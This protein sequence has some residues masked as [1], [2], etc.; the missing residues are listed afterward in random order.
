MSCA[1][2]S[3]R[4]EKAVSALDGVKEC[5]V[6]LLT[7]TMNVEG[8]ATREQIIAAVEKAGYGAA[9]ADGSDSSGSEKTDKKV[10]K[11]EARAFMV[12]LIS[13]AVL[14]CVLMYFSMGHS[15][16]G[17]RVPAFFEDNYIAEAMLQMLLCIAVMVI[18]KKFFVSGFTALAHRAPNMDTLVAIGSG[19][20][21]VYSV[22]TVFSMTAD[23]G[24]HAM[25]LVHSLYFESAAMIL[26]LI[27][28]GKTLEA[29]SKGKTTS[30]LEE[31]I[32]LTP[33]TACVIRDGKEETIPAKDVRVG[34]IYVVR[35]GDS[36][37]ADGVIVK[38]NSAINESVLTGESIPAD[39][40]EGDEVHAATINT[41]GYLECRATRVG[42]DTALSQII[43]LVSDA[44]ATKAP[45]AKTADRVAG[46]FVPAVM[47]IA[48]LTFISWMIT[49]A[50]VGYA[51]ARAI[52]VLVISCPCALGLATPVA[53][54]VASGVGAKNGIL[55]KSAASIEAAGRI[56]TV[57]L[58]KTGTVTQGLPRV[59]DIITAGG[60]SED[61][62]LRTACSLEKSSEH[63]LA[64]AVCEY[65][66]KKGTELFPVD[67]FKALP[68]S[69]V[70]ADYNGGKLRG[71]NLKSMK[72][73]AGKLAEHADRL[74][75]EGKTPLFFASGERPLGIIAV[76]DTVKE[77]SAEAI[78]RLKNM[79]VRVVMLTGDNERTAR[80]VA[81]SVGIDEVVAG[82][83]PDGKEKVVRELSREGK[84]AM[85]GDGI[86]DSPALAGADVGIAIGAGADIA[87]DSA[88]IVLVG[89]RLDGV[90]AAIGLGRAALRNIK[91]N[92]FWAF[93]YNTVGIPIAA[94]AFA[95]FGL[96]LSPMFGA[97]AMSLS[98]V[99]VVTNALRLNL[100]KVHG[101][102]AKNIKSETK[103]EIKNEI[104]EKETDKM[105]KV[106]KVEGMMCAHCEAHV[107]QA[108]EAL[109]GVES[110]QADHTA[111][112]VKLK[113]KG[114]V[115][116]SEI[117][118]AVADAGY[119]V[120]K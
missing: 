14:L 89:S 101:R 34:D 70:E 91:E 26:T 22:Y 39:K 66:E 50:Q 117:E 33:A 92:L 51:L 30:A 118:R 84:V 65:G 45:I 37:P 44:S 94:G 106:I 23:G 31:L 62:L 36:I 53:V 15:M 55:Y 56:K 6:N 38:G 28:V 104:T 87:I 108:L 20:A 107:K 60:V 35:P 111:G 69:G 48:A 8:E 102:H 2:C 110:A 61:E 83:L 25:H 52:S 29:H 18:N 27:T 3:A 74:S 76:A 75:S 114:E 46:V 81:A 103:T 116:D 54:M 42:E 78:A 90:P 49:G 115:A 12:R 109:T 77:E 1:A 71:G 41:S 21:F 112:E 59:T 105:E 47:S 64:R 7:G 9:P 120:V 113:L 16:W 32:S 85:V 73:W 86:N 13:S 67:N 80:A 72:A 4:V 100:Y 63:P 99:C 88:D 68:G 40:A 119:K 10:K 95:H 57:A 43:K 58:D 79:G 82:V 24:M 97:A 96:E 5:S 17:W 11:T 19:A 98:S 93:I